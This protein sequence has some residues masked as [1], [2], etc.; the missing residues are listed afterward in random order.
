MQ[1]GEEVVGDQTKE[2]LISGSRDKSIM[3]WD[4]IER[5]DNDQDKEWGIPRKILRGTDSSYF[6]KF[7]PFTLC[8][9]FNSLLGQQICLDCLLGRN[10][11]TV[12]LEKGSYHKEICQPFKRCTYLCFLSWQQ[13]DCQW[14]K[15]QELENLEHCWRMQVHSWW[16]CSLRLGFMRKILSRHKE[17][18]RCQCFMG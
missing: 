2:F 16:K 7:R 10:F 3:I 13:T 14:W 8:S 17:P 5:G 12:G 18:H 9:G 6:T 11:E 1:V 15:R 4:I